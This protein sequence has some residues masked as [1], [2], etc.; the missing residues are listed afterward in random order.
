MTR[1]YSIPKEFW[2]SWSW[3]K[4]L[5]DISYSLIPYIV[6]NL[7]SF[8]FKF[9]FKIQLV[10]IKILLVILSR[11]KQ[12][13]TSSTIQAVQYN[14]SHAYSIVFLQIGGREG[15]FHENWFEILWNYAVVDEIFMKISRNFMNFREISWIFM[16][17]STLI[18]LCFRKNFRH[19]P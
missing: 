10:I 5:F 7:S 19:P 17:K 3:V 4:S 15:L 6:W 8:H 12:Y 18:L 9:Y 2:I 11:L 1:N 14:V 13:N 16:Y